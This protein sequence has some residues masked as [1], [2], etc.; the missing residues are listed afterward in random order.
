MN[1]LRTGYSE[2]NNEDTA[3]IKG[4]LK[5]YFICK[6][7]ISKKTLLVK[8]VTIERYKNYI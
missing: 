8:N 1:I 3:P 7:E 5:V 4:K 2:P 6:I